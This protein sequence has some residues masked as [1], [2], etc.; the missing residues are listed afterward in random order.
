MERTI[1][2]KNGEST[3]RLVAVGLSSKHTPPNKDEVVL[4]G[5]HPSQQKTDSER[6]T[7]VQV[8]IRPLPTPEA[9]LTQSEA[10]LNA[11]IESRTFCTEMCHMIWTNF[12]MRQ[13]KHPCDPRDAS[14]TQPHE[15]EG[16]HTEGN[17]FCPGA[18]GF[19][20]GNC[21]H[22]APPSFKVT[23]VS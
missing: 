6:N 18:V 10:S 11:W 2:E 4:M 19:R 5:L 16:L 22:L 23:P 21:S 20:G 7:R 3:P 9:T 1:V 8:L 15:G 17:D 14:A 12:Q 13:R